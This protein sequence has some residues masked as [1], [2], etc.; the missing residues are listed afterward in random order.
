M[1]IAI[2]PILAFLLSTAH[3]HT[4]V[5]TEE[6]IGIWQASPVMASGWNDTYLFYDDGTVTFHRNQMQCDK[7][8][9]TEYG[10]WRLLGRYG[11]TLDILIQRKE[12]LV[13]GYK[14]KSTGSCASDY[15]IEGGEV[16]M[17]TLERAEGRLMKLRSYTFDYAFEKPRMLIGGRD[18]WKFSNEPDGYYW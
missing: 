18:F 4:L 13:G 3:H 6:L 11:D 10:T 1:H 16:V 12:K 2:I 5:T 17:D 15:E 7:R 14:V 9:L 8:E